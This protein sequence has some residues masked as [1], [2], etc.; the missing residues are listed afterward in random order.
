MGET[1]R[2]RDGKRRKI[3]TVARQS[4]DSWE[5]I[6]LSRNLM[7]SSSSLDLLQFCDATGFEFNACICFNT[8]LSGDFWTSV[9]EKRG[10]D[11]LVIGAV[12]LCSLVLE[13]V[14]GPDLNRSSS[15]R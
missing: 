4:R 3:E 2:R 5:H 10:Y 1:L 11:L 13:V 14:A 8:G 7:T 9:S 15:K 12:R 6:D